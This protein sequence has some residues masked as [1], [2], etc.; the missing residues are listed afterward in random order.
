[1]SFTC[2]TVGLHTVGYQLIP[3]H[4]IKEVAG[5]TPITIKYV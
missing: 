1:M 3:L 2:T 5:I 4:Q